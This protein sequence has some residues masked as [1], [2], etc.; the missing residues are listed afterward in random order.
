MEGFFDELRCARREA[1]DCRAGARLPEPE[2]W[3]L[4]AV[5]DPARGGA[6][7][8]VPH[9]GARGLG[10]RRLHDRAEGA[11]P[12][13]GVGAPAQRGV[14]RAP[15]RRVRRARALE[16]HRARACSGPAATCCVP[17][18]RGSTK[19]ELQV[20]CSTDLELATT[21]YFD[22]VPDG[23]A[24]LAFHFSGSVIYADG[25]RPDAGDARALARDGPVPP[26]G[27]GL[28]H[29]ARAT[30]ALV[31]AGRGHVRASCASYASERALLSSDAAVADLLAAARAEATMSPRARR[32]G[33]LAALRGLRPLPV[34][35]RGHEERHAH[36]VRHRL[37]ARLRRA[38]PE[39][40][41]A[42]A[43][44]VRAARATAR[45]RAR[46]ASSSPR[47][48]GTRARR[49]GSTSREPGLVEFDHPPL[50]GR[51]RLR[52]EAR[53]DGRRL[54]SLCVHNETPL[55]GA[56]RRPRRG[57]AALAA[58][59]PTW[60]C[61]PRRAASSRRSTSPGTT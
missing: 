1:C 61:A 9:A 48:S 57:A 23:H 19:F 42:A 45:C 24:P 22:A 17:S 50:R 15:A 53:D 31:R 27:R 4:D 30:A 60:C 39:L 52:T 26:A 37:P 51:V 59:P 14:A 58:S 11:D 29:G 6:H 10:S 34:H 47:A 36:A 16:R 35:A 8:L 43:D 12:A 46:C 32:A 56:G 40:L 7:A 13:R 55:D 44:R 3:V 5:A 25:P 28:A 33:R 38:Q 41:R 21:R 20:P 54:V 49:A 18:F 2:F